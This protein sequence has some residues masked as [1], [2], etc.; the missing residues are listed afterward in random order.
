[1]RVEI[2]IQVSQTPTE[3]EWSIIRVKARSLPK[4]QAPFHLPLGISVALE[5]CP[6]LYCVELK[7]F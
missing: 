4:K 5:I 7:I 2:R 1:M 6:L 3:T